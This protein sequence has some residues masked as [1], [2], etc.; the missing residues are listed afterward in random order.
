MKLVRY[1]AMC[2]A[3]AAAYEVDEV[4]GWRDKARAIEMYSRQAKNHEA[5]RQ[6]CEIRL[7]AERKC[8]K[9]LREREKAKGARGS[10]SNQHEVRSH[11]TTAPRLDDLGISKSQSSQ[12]QRLADIPDE[13]FELALSG[14]ERP[15]T[16]GIIARQVHRKDPVDLVDEKALWLWGRIKDFKRDGVLNE[17]PR[18][19][20]H[21][22]L[23]HMK[24]TMQELLPL[25]IDWLRKVRS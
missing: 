25:V 23:P 19:I 22:M 17:D 13:D 12:W 6:A 2:T 1:D 18:A 7:R 4:K 11:D 15:T 20:C 9:L 5:E 24:E 8:G 14:D 16:N 21:T 3:I 10:G